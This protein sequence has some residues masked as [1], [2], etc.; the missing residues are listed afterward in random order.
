MLRR[1]GDPAL[2][3]RP[4]TP[5]VEQLSGARDGQSDEGAPARP[6][7]HLAGQRGVWAGDRPRV[8]RGGMPKRVKR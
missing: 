3:R 1:E 5:Q 8:K 6:M 4:D 2:G 7:H